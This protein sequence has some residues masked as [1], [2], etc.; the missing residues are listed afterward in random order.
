MRGCHDDGSS[1]WPPNP[2]RIAD[3][4]RH[5]SPALLLD[6]KRSSHAELHPTVLPTSDMRVKNLTMNCVGDNHHSPSLATSSRWKRPRKWP[7][8]RAQEGSS[9]GAGR[10]NASLFLISCPCTGRRIARCA[11][12]GKYPCTPLR[13][14]PNRARYPA[15]ET[16]ATNPRPVPRCFLE[17]ELRGRMPLG[18]R[19]GPDGAHSLPWRTEKPTACVG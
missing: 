18:F 1:P 16:L 11:R 9:R 17:R 10:L 19:P 12:C 5:S 4:S 6:A 3:S 8:I 7:R 15:R 2:E 14:L 13:S